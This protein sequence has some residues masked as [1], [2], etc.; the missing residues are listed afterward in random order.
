MAADTLL[1]QTQSLRADF[2]EKEN[3]L[4]AQL[5]REGQKPQV[6][7]IGCSDSR[8][9]PEL[10][11][12][13]RPGQ[14]FVVRNVAN[15]IPPFGIGHWSVGAAIEYAVNH[16]KVAH[17]VICGH[18]ECGGIKALDSRMDAL[19]EPSLT[20]W[21]E[22]AREAQTRVDG[23]GVEKEK[24]HRAIVEQNIIL[25][26]ERAAGYPAVGKA[27]QENRIELHGWLFDLHG[28][29]VYSYNPTTKQFEAA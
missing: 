1:H 11:T 20:S 4:L 15:I 6:M 23:R 8:V 16:L 12:G 9:V 22:L 17:L 21:V 29:L 14:V 19:A 26:L 2:F 7:F 13:A 28:P 5:A 18:T 27:L 24:R 25:Q 3:D 10:L